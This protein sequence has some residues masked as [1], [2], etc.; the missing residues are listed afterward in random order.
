MNGHIDADG[1]AEYRV[2]L[3]TGRRE[4]EIAAHLVTCAQ[5]ASVADRLAEVSVLLAAVPAPAMPDAVAARLQAALDAETPIAAENT[6]VTPLR[7]RFRL[8]RLSPVRVLTPVA[9]LFVLAAGAFGLSQL[10]SSP[11]G[12]HVPPAAAAAGGAEAS[13]AAAAPIEG[14]FAT[15]HADTGLAN[16]VGESPL[17]IV[18]SD[19]NLERATLGKQLDTLLGEHSGL[20]TKQAPTALKA[21]VRALAAGRSVHLVASALYRG[22]PATIAIVSN[23]TSYLG[24]VAGSHCSPTNSDILATAVVSSGISTP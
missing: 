13:A 17:M 23:G 10:G 22:S 1:I 4:H 16:G 15:G 18:V 19:A 3:I 24:L 7:P 21:C 9:A 2:G 12:S 5:C 8:P 6:V 14:S 11:A 20:H